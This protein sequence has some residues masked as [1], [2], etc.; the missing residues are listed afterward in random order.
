MSDSRIRSIKW[1]GVL[2]AVASSIAAIIAGDIPTAVGII[3][4][5]LSSAGILSQPT[6]N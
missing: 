6:H 3:G 4:A 1:L 2:A 5:S